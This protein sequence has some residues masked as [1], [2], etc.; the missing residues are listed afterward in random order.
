MWKV[1]CILDFVLDTG[2]NCWLLS[3][4]NGSKSG[5]R[6]KGRTRRKKRR[7]RRFTIIKNHYFLKFLPAAQ[8]TTQLTIHPGTSNHRNHVRNPWNLRVFPIIGRAEGQVDR[9][10]KKVREDVYQK[11]WRPSCWCLLLAAIVH[12]CGT[13]RGCVLCPRHPSSLTSPSLGVT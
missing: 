8:P 2:Y 1:C 4:V 12:A 9:M 13:R 7:L 3:T 5:P 11:C 10:L 6:G